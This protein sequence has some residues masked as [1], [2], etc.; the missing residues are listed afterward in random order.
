MYCTVHPR[1]VPLN[2]GNWYRLPIVDYS[3]ARPCHHP[4]VTSTPSCA[5]PPSRLAPLPDRHHPARGR[6]LTRAAPAGRRR[7]PLL[8][9]AVVAVDCSCMAAR[10]VA[11][12]VKATR[13][14]SSAVNWSSLHEQMGG[15]GSGLAGGAKTHPPGS[16]NW[17]SDPPPSAER[18]PPPHIAVVPPAA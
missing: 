5:P 12:A 16:A 18:A 15:R 14:V 9:R 8:P 7:L 17:P 10:A 11:A 13:L 2:D 4:E 3:I 1:H 6:G